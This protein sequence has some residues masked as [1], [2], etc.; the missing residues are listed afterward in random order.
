V[1][2]KIRGQYFAI[3]NDGLVPGSSKGI[4]LPTS[5]I[6]M[7]FADDGRAFAGTFDSL[8]ISENGAYNEVMQLIPWVHQS[9]YSLAAKAGTFWF[10]QADEL[11]EIRE[12][13]LI[14]HDLKGYVTGGS[15]AMLFDDEGNIWIGTQYDGLVRLT[16][17]SVE[18]VSDLTDME[19]A[20]INSIVED[21][22]GAVWLGGAQLF[23]VKDRSVSELTKEEHRG[24]FVKSLAVDG[25]GVLWVLANIGL[26]RMD[27]EKLLRVPEPDYVGLE[28]HAMFF[29]SA[30]N[31]WIGSTKG[32]GRLAPNGEYLQYTTDNGLVDNG[33]HFITQTHDG[34]LW[35]GR[36]VGLAS[37]RTDSLKT[38]RLITG[39]RRDTSAI[40]K[41]MTMELSGSEPTA[42]YRPVA[43]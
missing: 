25:N 35:I 24:G 5:V 7:I 32:L 26:F 22:E 10:Q 11:I 30:W 40:S 29:D 37:S 34:T 15:R 18:L 4:L 31:L 28:F 20:G 8:G 14:H 1:W 21:K 9:G 13:Q 41:K 38:L 36:W 3:E 27:N 33:V 43:G 12:G 2:V 6:R 19:I 16:R 42:G 39:C 23:R 17:R